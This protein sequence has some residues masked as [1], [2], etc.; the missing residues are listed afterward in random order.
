MVENCECM[1]PMRFIA[2]V[3]YPISFITAKSLAWSMEPK[4]FLKSM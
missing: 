3:G 4:A 1:F 2:S